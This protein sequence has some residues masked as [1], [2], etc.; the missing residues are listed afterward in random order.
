MCHDDGLDLNTTSK[1]LYQ[2]KRRGN[3]G[4]REGRE[5]GVIGSRRK[6]VK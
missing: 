3:E 4:W 2:S 5:C 6:R 1:Q